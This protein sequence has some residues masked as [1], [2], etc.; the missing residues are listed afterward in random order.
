MQYKKLLEPLKI[1]SMELKNRMVVPAM[2]T[3]FANEDGT[4]TEKFMA[5]HEAKARGG[6]GLIITEDFTVEENAGG[7]K[8]LPS[9][10]RD[11]LIEPYHAF[12][13]RIHKAGGKIA[14]QI[15]HAGR[16][17]TSAVTGSK[18]IAPSAIKEP[19]IEEIPEAMSLSR[20]NELIKHFGDCAARV[21]AAGF[22]A[23]EIHGAHGYLIGAFVSPFSNKRTDAYG[24]NIAGRARFAVEVAKEIRERV[25][26]DFPILYR[27]STVEYVEG[28][29]SIE[30]AK[31]L[32]CMLEEAGVDCIHCSQ[33]VYVTGR[34][35]IPSALV[36]KG[37][38]T[39]NAAAIRSVVSIPIIAVGHIPDPEMAESVLRS[40]KADLVAMGRASIA[41]PFMPKKI[42]E[43]RTENILRCI[44]CRQGCSARSSAGEPILCMVNPLTGMEDE[45]HIEPAQ[46][47]K[48]VLVVGGGVSGCTAAIAAA[49]RGHH[50]MLYEKD[51][52]L[53]GQWIAAS[54]P[55]GKADFA[56]F[57]QWQRSK[58]ERL[59]IGVHLG[60]AVTAELVEE[61]APDTIINASGSHP[62]VPPIQGIHSNHVVYAS[63]V[64]NGKKMPGN[65]V[66]VIGGGM[67]GLETAAHLAI[68]GSKVTLLEMLPRVGKDAETGT[69]Y[70]V[71]EHLR[72]HNVLIHTSAKVLA[73]EENAIRAEKDGQPLDITEVDMVVL[74]AGMAKNTD[75][76]EELA[77]YNVINVGDANRVKNGFANIQEAFKIGYEI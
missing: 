30:D 53:G 73:V 70:H 51:S 8:C 62:L 26:E 56:S 6:W 7:Y 22:D 4:P 2:V 42:V 47:P 52:E 37:L 67:V 43:G 49:K 14:A 29:F 32:A 34:C 10:C 3:N 61:L 33:G 35:I 15:Y 25:G 77:R 38:Y 60:T 54:M 75:V 45:Y 1:R 74:A 11:D 69:L 55:A 58:M 40:N 20:I 19:T 59:G 41:D 65:H 31:V 50:V 13:D 28:G 21:K 17:T 44:G 68:H 71:M 46:I 66:A 27:M 12:T 63:D 24:G 36:P 39:D 57:I 64:L 76:T 72:N 23:V 16:E 9:L 5:Y 48:K 18:P